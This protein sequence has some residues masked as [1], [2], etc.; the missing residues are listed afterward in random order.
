MLSQEDVTGL[1]LSGGRGQRMGGIDKGLQILHGR[2]LFLHAVERLQPQTASILV[3]A[4]R[5][6]HIYEKAGFPVVSDD[7]ANAFAGPLAGFLAGLMHCQTPFMVTVPCD[8]PFYPATLVP[9]LKTALLQNDADIAIAVT[10]LEAPFSPQPV[11]CLMR[12]QLQPHLSAF[13]QSGQR[14]IDHWFSGLKVA[15]AH[16]ENEADFY[17]INT[18]EALQKLESR[19]L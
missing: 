6:L 9:E 5:H 11:F 12:R 10:G 16:F 4:N 18:A 8:C 17:N 14:K 2:P 1:V 13:L 19:P 7:V 3:S 15:H